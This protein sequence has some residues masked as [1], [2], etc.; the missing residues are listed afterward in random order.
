MP[1]FVGK[2][3]Q[4]FLKIRFP[5]SRGSLQPVRFLKRDVSYFGGF[6]QPLHFLKDNLLSL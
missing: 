4:Y 5:T 3:K 1:Y 2:L 6:Y